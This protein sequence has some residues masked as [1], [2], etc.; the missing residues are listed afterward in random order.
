MKFAYQTVNDTHGL[1]SRV[2]EAVASG[3]GLLMQHHHA[4]LHGE[5]S[6]LY[7]SSMQSFDQ[8]KVLSSYES[9]FL[10]QVHII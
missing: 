10:N 7:F 9:L 8:F 4:V 5:S 2:H 3:L 1:H 6:V